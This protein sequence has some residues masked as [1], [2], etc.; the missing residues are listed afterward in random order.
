MYLLRGHLFANRF[1]SKGE[2]IM[3]LMYRSTRS[4]GVK[5][6]FTQAVLK[7][8][9][10]DGGL[11]VPDQ[12]PIF[13]FMNREWLG[14]S[15]QD[16]SYKVMSP[17]MPEIE[18]SDLRKAIASAYD[19]KFAEPRIAPLKRIGPVHILELFH[20]RTLAFKDMALSLL[21]H[22]IQLAQKQV[23]GL[24][25]EI[26]I[27]TATSG[28]TGKAALEAFSDV[29]GT[30]IIVFYPTDGVSDIQKRQMAT[31]GGNN[32]HVFGING[33]FDDAQTA[34]KA[35]FS[36][37]ELRGRM[38]KDHKVFSSAN[39]MN[40]GR[41][42]PQ[43]AYYV[44]AYFEMV[45]R[46]E[47]LQGDPINVVVPTGNFGNILAAY[48][49]KQLGL[50][51]GKLI[52]A[53]NANKV[54]TDFFRDGV[55]DRERPFYTTSSPSMDILISSNLERLLFEVA[56]RDTQKLNEWMD[57]LKTQGHYSLSDGDQSVLEM[58]YADFCDD[59]ETASA[60]KN[61][62]ESWRYVA[63]PHTA[64]ALKVYE[65][66]REQ[67]GD[68][69]KTVVVSTASP[70]KFS[71]SV[72]KA[73][74]PRVEWSEVSEVERL[75]ALSQSMEQPLPKPLQEVLEAPIRHKDICDRDA[76]QK[77]VEEVLG[78]V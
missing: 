52:C 5:L 23:L 11:Y 56:H 4:E 27:L 1:E 21:P 44:N 35:I 24:K 67:S 53:S 13:D 17:F 65:K 63:D 47:I 48:Y 70:F 60:I 50:P 71:E 69:Q 55:Y 74:D 51:I 14:L 43:M 64:V 25:A 58:F 46:G 9:A 57:K 37:S 68:T 40:V 3:S 18:E 42:I 30:R 2:G 54:L 28:D 72:L 26:V 20:G 32:V 45:A 76:I 61:T 12:W 7:G 77:V 38:E 41:L 16:L 59:S 22:F 78:L 10:D 39:S 15:Y 49:V 33:N 6:P 8:L 19:I 73:L 29:E 66:Y 31:Q 36:D 34:V 75:K 62:F